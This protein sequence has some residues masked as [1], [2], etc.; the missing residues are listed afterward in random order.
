VDYQVGFSAF[1]GG[2]LC[3]FAVAAG[4]FRREYAPTADVRVLLLAVVGYALM[5]FVAAQNGFLTA[6]LLLLGL[7]SMRRR[8][9]LAGVA[10]ACLTVKPQLGLLIPLLLVFDRNWRALAWSA[11]LTVLLVGVST[12]L[13]GLA[14][15]SAYLTDTLSYQRSVMTDWYGIFL[16]MMP[17]VFGSMRSLGFSPAVALQAQVPVM[18]CA[19]GAV[20]WLLWRERDPLRRAFTVLCGTFLVTPYAFNYDMGGLCVCAALLAGQPSATGSRPLSPLPIALVAA[21]P[22]AV[23]NLGRMG[24]P[25]T[26]LILAAGL[27]AL[28]VAARPIKAHAVETPVSA[29]L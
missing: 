16:R 2:T 21:I 24:L 27:M 26:P 14:S 20:L 22:A 7:A 23:T 28:I 15:W 17:T 3:L 19:L 8:P 10:F 9:A 18:V 4:V 29:P 13:F 5:M 25:C 12:A 11:A 6:A 1:M